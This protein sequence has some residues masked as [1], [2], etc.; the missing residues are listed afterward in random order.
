MIGT[1]V[2][3]KGLSI[4]C[5]IFAALAPA[6]AAGQQN[7]GGPSTD[8]LLKSIGLTKPAFARAPDF[9]LRDGGGGM[10]SLS[11]N[12]GNLILLN[13]WATWCGP[14]REEM[15]SMEQLSRSFGGQGFTILAVNQRESAAQVARYMKTNGLN[16]RVPLAYRWPGHRPPIRV[17]GIPATYLIDANGQ[18]IGMKSG[19][20]DWAA[21]EVVDV[22]RKL[23]A[24][25]GGSGSVGG[26]MELE[27]AAPLPKKLRAKGH[28]VLVHGQQDAQ[29]EIIGK[30]DRGDDLIRSAKSPAPASSGTW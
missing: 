6:F 5:L 29:S 1:I 23:I 20:R 8:E 12:R 26:S 4:I 17:Y 22:F 7:K 18:A 11:G 14:C 10:A 15:P 2:K 30:L 13:F 25:G 3:F 16:F 9:N 28:G 24:D 27:P 19:T 21:R